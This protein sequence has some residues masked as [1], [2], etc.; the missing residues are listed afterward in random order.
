MRSCRCV[1]TSPVTPAE[2][3][4]LRT[5]RDSDRAYKDGY[6]QGKA[7]GLAEQRKW[8]DLAEAALR[9]AQFERNEARSRVADL[10]VSLQAA[11]A[12]ADALN[13]ACEAL[14]DVDPDDIREWLRARAGSL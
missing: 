12:G 6:D 7:H 3:T 9:E 14:E 5:D 13:E 1:V 8:R 11:K 10:E 4:E 2:N